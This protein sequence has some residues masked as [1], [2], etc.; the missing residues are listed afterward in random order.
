MR[1]LE[2]TGRFWTGPRPRRRRRHPDVTAGRGRGPDRGTPPGHRTGA[3]AGRGG[4][5]GRRRRRS[6]LVPS[7]RS[8]SGRPAAPR[9]SGRPGCDADLLAGPPQRLSGDRQIAALRPNSP[10]RPGWGTPQRPGP[11]G[12]QDRRHLCGGVRG[13][14]ALP[15]FEPEL[16]RPRVEV[17]GRPSP[18]GLIL[19][20][21]PN[22]IGQGIEFDYS[23]ARR[24]HAVRVRPA[25]RPSWSTATPRPLSTDYDTATG[26]TSNR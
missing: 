19:G 13:V 1:S 18:K 2:T 9:S 16:D 15:L 6:T 12:V 25:T 11:P 14:D 24:D 21:G 3:A 26:C 4:R 17:P 5:A 20:S 8:R 10:A 23:C 7:T 22:R